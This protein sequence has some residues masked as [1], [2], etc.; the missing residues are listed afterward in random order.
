MRALFLAVALS[1][2]SVSFAATTFTCVT[3]DNTVVVEENDGQLRYRSWNV[4]KGQSSKP[5][6]EI[7]K[8]SVR[9]EGTGPCRHKIYSFLNGDY[10]YEVSPGLGCT[11]GSEPQGATGRL[12]VSKGE[13]IVAQW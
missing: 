7:K 1:V 10:Q 9:F 4:P 11:D 2:P 5:D 8:G 3:S 6:L 13:S 12:T